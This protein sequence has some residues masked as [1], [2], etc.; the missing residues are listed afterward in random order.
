[1]KDFLKKVIEENKK[2]IRY[3]GVD[4]DINEIDTKLV[5][6]IGSKANPMVIY[7]KMKSKI[8][9]NGWIDYE[10]YPIKKYYYDKGFLAMTM[11]TRQMAEEFDVNRKSISKAVHLLDELGWIS[12]DKLKTKKNF[13]LQNVYVFGFWTKENG[14]KTVEIFF[15]SP[16]REYA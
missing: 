12:I 5:P 3:V 6:L 11:S 16:F 13:Q 2:R 15:N 7:L 1:M 9:R 8:V 4:I 14:G 10:G